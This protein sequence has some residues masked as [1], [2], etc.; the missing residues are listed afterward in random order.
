MAF[1]LFQEPAGG[2]RP[3]PG[4]RPLHP[5]DQAEEHAAIPDGGE[6]D[7]PFG[8]RV[9]PGRLMKYFHR[10]SVTPDQVIDAA[11]RFFRSNFKT[12][13]EQPRRI[14]FAG[15]IGSIG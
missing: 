13:E 8:D 5:A 2:T 9:L 11:R 3:L 7:H 4:T 1:V 12:V 6:T 14:G 10:T 15:A